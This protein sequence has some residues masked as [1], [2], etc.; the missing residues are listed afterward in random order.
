MAGMKPN[1]RPASQTSETLTDRA[2]GTPER[3]ALGRHSMGSMVRVALFA[4]LFILII[5]TLFYWLAR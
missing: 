1:E 3:A 2:Q 4:I 5:G